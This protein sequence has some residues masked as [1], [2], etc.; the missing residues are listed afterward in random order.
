MP[1]VIPHMSGVTDQLHHAT[2]KGAG[3][4]RGVQSREALTMVRDLLAA[5]VHARR[6][7]ESCEWEFVMQEEL[8][9]TGSEYAL[10][11]DTPSGSTRPTKLV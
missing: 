8:R 4:S 7:I 11:H 9:E 1:E 5:L 2:N 10:W 3:R 6:Q